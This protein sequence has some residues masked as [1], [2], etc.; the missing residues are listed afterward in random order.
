MTA[1]KWSD[2]HSR[3]IAAGA[4]DEVP[5]AE[6]D[7]LIADLSA[8][9][10]ERDEQATDFIERIQK[11]EAH[12]KVL[13]EERRELTGERDRLLGQYDISVHEGMRWN[14]RAEKAV[15]RVKELREALEESVMALRR[16]W[17]MFDAIC[18]NDPSTDRLKAR[19]RAWNAHVAASASLS[20]EE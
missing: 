8:C 15:A 3:W 9:E 14:D 11:A 10:K 17:E 4:V 5:D 6:C 2:W 19:D 18:K 20:K 13:E 12:V 7:A 1:S 16:A